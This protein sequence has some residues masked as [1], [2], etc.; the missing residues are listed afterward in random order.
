MTSHLLRL[1]ARFTTT[2]SNTSELRR[3]LQCNSSLWVTQYSLTDL[4]RF[5]VKNPAN[6]LFYTA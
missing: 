4:L 6:F 1:G 5:V 3:L 2:E